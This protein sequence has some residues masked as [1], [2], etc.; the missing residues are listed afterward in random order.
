MQQSI[1]PLHS[2]IVHTIKLSSP[3]N[4]DVI[5]VYKHEKTMNQEMIHKTGTV[6]FYHSLCRPIPNV[7][8]CLKSRH[9]NST[10]NYNNHQ[11]YHILIITLKIIIK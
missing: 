7:I 10:H 11:N 4:K 2:Q 8:L 3:S 9:Q 1:S 6:F 5:I